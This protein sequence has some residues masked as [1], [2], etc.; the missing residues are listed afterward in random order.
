MANP[1][2]TPPA[3]AA[4]DANAPLA[5]DFDALGPV[6]SDEE[7]EAIMASITRSRPLPLEQHIF[8]PT[9]RK[10]Q[11]VRMKEMLAN[12]LG[13]SRGSG[14]FAT[15][16]GERGAGSVAVGDGGGVGAGGTGGGGGG[17]GTGAG[18][19]GGGGNGAGGGEAAEGRRNS[20]VLQNAASASGL[21]RQGSLSMGQPGQ[22]GQPG[23]AHAQ[24]QAQAQARKASVA[25]TVGG[26]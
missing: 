26:P 23:H 22:S 13:G 16:T 2:L 17:A 21:G 7:K 4:I 6:D 15:G 8:L 10:Y 1:L 5:D 11:Y 24:A 25:S 14:L 18:V 3:E 9:R 19:T 20:H 12:A